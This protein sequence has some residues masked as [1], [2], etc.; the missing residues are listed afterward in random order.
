MDGFLLKSAQLRARAPLRHLTRQIQDAQRYRIVL[1][2]FDRVLGGERKKS[3]RMWL[4]DDMRSFAKSGL[5]NRAMQNGR[6]ASATIGPRRAAR[7]VSSD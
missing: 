4:R 1:E 3:D 7:S 5:Q 2:H 6:R